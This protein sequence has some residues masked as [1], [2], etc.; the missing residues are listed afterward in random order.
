MVNFK[1]YPNPANGAFTVEGAKEVAIYNTLG[2]AVA[3]SHSE[4]ETHSFTLPSGIYFIKAD[5][6]VKKVVVE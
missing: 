3:T 5:E 4:E 1:V 6:M 2:Q